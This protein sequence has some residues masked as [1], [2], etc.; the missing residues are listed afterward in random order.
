MKQVAF[1]FILFYYALG[2]VILPSSDFSILPKLPS[3]FAHCKATED[4]DMTIL[5]FITDHLMNIDGVFDAHEQ[6]DDQKPHQPFDCKI[7]NALICIVFN[8]ISSVIS[9][10]EIKV[11]NV[12]ITNTN[13]KFDFV[14]NIFRPPMV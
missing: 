3:L 13:Y 10:N 14:G 6:G 2:S 1:I 5:D 8:P 12:F 9:V 7:S 11:E 4:K